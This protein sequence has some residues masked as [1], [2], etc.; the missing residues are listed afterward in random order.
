M[1]QFESSWQCAQSG[2]CDHPTIMIIWPLCKYT[3]RILDAQ[4]IAFWLLCPICDIAVSNLQR[5]GC[6]LGNT[7]LKSQAAFSAVSEFQQ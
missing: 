5:A 3:Y 6:S 1:H 2:S 4:A 7:Y